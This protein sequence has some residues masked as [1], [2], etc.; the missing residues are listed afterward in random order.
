MAGKQQYTVPERLMRLHVPE[1]MSG[2]W[3]WL[4]T[5]NNK[6][7]GLMPLTHGRVVTA[8]RQSFIHWRGEIPPTLN[9]LHRCDVRRC[10]NP[11]HLFL[12]TIKDN[13]QDMLRKGRQA[14]KGY[15]HRR[16]TR[17]YLHVMG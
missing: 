11:A 9:V 6:G 14:Q 17:R 3:L 16:T 10:I 15:H 2:C 7:Y 4:G 13:S 12:G 5:V 8:H 1:P